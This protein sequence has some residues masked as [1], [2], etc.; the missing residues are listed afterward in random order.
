MCGS[1]SS[2]SVLI[3]AGERVNMSVGQLPVCLSVLILAG[4]R[5]NM[6]VGQLPVCV[7]V[8]VVCTNYSCFGRAHILPCF[9]VSLFVASCALI[10]FH[11]SGVK[12]TTADRKSANVVHFHCCCVKK[13]LQTGRVQML[14]ISIVVV[15]RSN[16]RQEE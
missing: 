6:C 10:H 1:A 15:L 5:G 2:P 3:L 13:Q 14:F 7:C 9:F 8:F 11:C 12:K 4:K 16:C